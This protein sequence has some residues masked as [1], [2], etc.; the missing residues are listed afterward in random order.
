MKRLD[1]LNYMTSTITDLYF[2]VQQQQTQLREIERIIISMGKLFQSLNATFDLRIPYFL[3][4]KQ[5]I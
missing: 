2:T 1:E 4:S 3:F 5:Y